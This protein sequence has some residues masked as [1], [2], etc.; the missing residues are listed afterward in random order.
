M[1][2]GRRD[3]SIRRIPIV[4][5]VRPGRCDVFVLFQVARVVQNGRKEDDVHNLVGEGLAARVVLKGLFDA[6]AV[7]VHVLARHVLHDARRIVKVFDP[8]LAIDQ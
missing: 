4:A 6:S 7:V 1:L 8:C 5:T 2:D 3:P